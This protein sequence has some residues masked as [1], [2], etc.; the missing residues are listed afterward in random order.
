MHLA[1]AALLSATPAPTLLCPRGR[2]L[3]QR[4]WC[5]LT[6]SSACHSRSLGSNSSRCRV[7]CPCWLHLH[8]PLLLLRLK[9]RWPALTGPECVSAGWLGMLRLRE[10]IRSSLQQPRGWKQQAGEKD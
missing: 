3:L 5:P 6:L 9:R 4:G 1:E 8:L 10:G 7:G 2:L